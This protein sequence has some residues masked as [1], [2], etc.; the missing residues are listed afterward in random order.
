M[1]R[2]LTIL[3]ALVIGLSMSAQIQ[4]TFLG[5]TLGT[6]T[7]SEVYEKYKGNDN[8]SEDKDGGYSVT[9]IE[10]AGQKWDIANFD[11]SD[12]L[13]LSVHFSML[14][15]F[16]SES[17]LDSVWENL[18]LKLM[19]KYGD[20]NYF[21]TSEY[22]LFKDDATKLSITN[23]Y[24]GGYKVLLIKYTDSALKDKQTQVNDSEL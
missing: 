9:N 12:D 7:K 19:E 21:S 4:R 17:I 18:R 11:F 14:S 10:F 24:A 3:L 8:F 16:T 23:S 6:T 1:K 15:M 5:F 20:Y 13:L 22:L 2:Y